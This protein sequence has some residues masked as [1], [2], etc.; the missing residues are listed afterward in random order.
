MQIK[1]LSK[2]EEHILNQNKFKKTPQEKEDS[3]RFK[4]E[5]K[6]LNPTKKK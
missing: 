5:W 3:K 2:E 1:P 4:S 6:K